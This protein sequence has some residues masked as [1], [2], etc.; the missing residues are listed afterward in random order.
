MKFLT[1]IVIIGALA[2][3]T[4][5]A[6][7]EIF[8]NKGGKHVVGRNNELG[9]N[10]A[11]ENKF[12]YIGQKHKT[13]LLLNDSKIPQAKLKTWTTKYGH[14][15]RA[16]TYGTYA[17]GMNTQGVSI[18]YQMMIGSKYP[19]YN[20]KD[21]RDVISIFDI[22]T[23]VLG[24]ASSTK[25]AIK[26]L[27]EL[28]HVESYT[29]FSMHEKPIFI[30]QHISIRD[31]SGHSAVIEFING[32]TIIHD[33][34]KNIMTNQ[35]TY[36]WQLKNAAKYSSMKVTNKKPNPEFENRVINYSAIY[37][38]TG[39]HKNQTAMLGIPGDFTPPSRFVRGSV[40]LDNMM[41]PKSSVEAR[42]QARSLIDAIAVFA[43][44]TKD[45]VL[46]QNIKD[47]DNGL[48]YYKN[49]YMFTGKDSLYANDIEQGFTKIDLNDIDFSV[50]PADQPK[51][52]NIK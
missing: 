43:V 25:E 5:Q 48:Y 38:M 17:D 19:K 50:I 26:L 45:L 40:W 39:A 3:T 12:G 6:C 10:V 11:F 1:K 47:L 41:A 16:V 28:Q 14:I 23:Y 44:T 34:A 15:G 9:I 29:Q 37:N 2:L 51:T 7:S 22:G 46:W 24:V 13:L 42:A 52:F 20:P 8:I 27:K 33:E 35:P 49:L 18:A 36:D 21:K 31:K 30:P 4:A 32:K